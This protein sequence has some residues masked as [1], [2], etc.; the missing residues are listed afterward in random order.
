MTARL[1][2]AD[3][4]SASDAATFARRA[5]RLGDGTAVRL[6]ASAGVL[7]LTTAVLAPRGL[8]DPS[9]TVLALR[10]AAVDP[11][12]VCDL[13]VEAALLVPGEDPATLALPETALSV[14][15]AGV[16]PPRSGWAAAG[17][18]SAAAIATAAQRGMAEVAAHTGGA[19][20]EEAL[21]TVRARVW[22]APE[23]ALHDLPLGAAFAASAL[24][25]VS[26]E[27]TALLLRADRWSR[28]TLSRG[29]VL[30]RG[31]VRSG[32]TPVRTTG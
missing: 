3:A 25:F 12:L 1:L 19:A 21:H 15:W 23:P 32:L 5:A 22:G 18:L 17:E 2:F 10:T 30:V 29:H 20:S 8:L 6:Q 24:G 27:E 13:V 11:E 26:G 7:A 28:L 31:P 9:P 16:A 14:G 4:A